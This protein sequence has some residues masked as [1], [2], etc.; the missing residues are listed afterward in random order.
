M[1]RCLS[2]EQIEQLLT[3]EADPESQEFF[4]GHLTACPL[5]RQTFTALTTVLDADQWQAAAEPPGAVA[6]EDRAFLDLLKAPQPIPDPGAGRTGQTAADSQ[7][8]G[9]E[10]GDVKQ[11][12]L[13]RPPPV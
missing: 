7:T 8:A 9:S 1:L 11:Y 13:W 10:N 5:C 12:L 6:A 2:S 4:G 3:G